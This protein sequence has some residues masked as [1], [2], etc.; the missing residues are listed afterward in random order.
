MVSDELGKQLHDRATRGEKLSTSESEQLTAWYA[1]QDAA[2]YKALAL[3]EDATEA[4]DA[5]LSPDLREQYR[6]QIS[7]IMQQ[8][9]SVTQNIQTLE[10]ENSAL[11]CEIATLRQRVA[12]QFISQP[13]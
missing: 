5:T 12:K 9:T 6:A 13:A 3:A 11:R 1:A 7:R 4:E 2:E 8:L 10:E